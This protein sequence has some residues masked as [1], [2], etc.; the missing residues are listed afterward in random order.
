MP[1]L[2]CVRN[3]GAQFGMN[4]Q[5][6]V[7]LQQGGGMH[8]GYHGGGYQ[9]GMPAQ[10]MHGGYHGGGYQ[11]GMP[12]QHMQGGC[13]YNGAFDNC[14][15]HCPC[16]HGQGD[17]DSNRDCM[18]GL[19][20][21]R[22]VGAQFGMNPQ[23]DVCL[24]QGGGMHG[25]YHGGGYQGGYQGG[26]PH[27]PPMQGGWGTDHNRDGVP[28]QYQAGG[29]CRNGC[30]WCPAGTHDEFTCQ[31]NMEACDYNGLFGEVLEAVDQCD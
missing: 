28:D 8:G 9:G 4:P 7:C 24:Q 20:C 12:A 19:T 18:P 1:G 10:Q 17:C 16:G 2:T 29:R 5:V 30:V 11:G 15:P 6:D 13:S 31:P 14:K 26:M 21:V 27:V 23:V 22:N 25:G 3:V